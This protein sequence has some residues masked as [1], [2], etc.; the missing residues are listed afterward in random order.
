V[1]KGEVLDSPYESKKVVLRGDGISLA[2]SESA[3]FVIYWDGTR[4]AY[5]Q[6]VD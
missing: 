6:T 3:A 4:F 1:P 5:Y 2:K